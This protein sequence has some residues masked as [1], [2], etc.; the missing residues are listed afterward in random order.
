MKR[1]LK[2]TLTVVFLAFVAFSVAC[3]L[4]YRIAIS[5]SW[6]WAYANLAPVLGYDISYAGSRKIRVVDI[7]GQDVP[8][9]GDANSLTYA[10]LVLKFAGKNP[11][12][13]AVEDFKRGEAKTIEMQPAHSDVYSGML[14]MGTTCSTVR[15]RVWMYGAYRLE[16]FGIGIS[17]AIAQKVRQYNI[18]LTL[19]PMYQE[20]IAHYT[21]TYGSQYQP[22]DCLALPRAFG[23]SDYAPLSIQLAV[24]QKM[25]KGPAVDGDVLREQLMQLL[26]LTPDAYAAEKVAYFKM[27]EIYRAAVTGDLDA[28]K[29]YTGDL[30][31]PGVTGE[32][33]LDIAFKSAVRENADRSVYVYLLRKTS[34]DRYIRQAARNFGVSFLRENQIPFD[35]AVLIQENERD[36]L[37]LLHK[38]R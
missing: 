10:Q 4:Y 14:S 37:N 6:M 17:F 19:L 3:S 32:T 27:N 13:L 30:S 11:V 35:E 31:R 36:H 1:A 22:R 38:L 16:T 15:S 9:Q 29:S 28:V 18:A 12:N 20:H 8:R 34:D 2:K 5:D 26:N 23:E 33:L 7:D 24:E 21:H 25:A